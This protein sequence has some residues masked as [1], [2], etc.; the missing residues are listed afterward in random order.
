MVIKAVF[1]LRH[2]CA[3]KERTGK[4]DIGHFLINTV[5]LFCVQQAEVAYLT[6]LISKSFLGMVNNELHCWDLKYFHFQNSISK[7]S[8]LRVQWD[9]QQVD[10]FVQRNWLASW[11][12]HPLRLNH[13]STSKNLSYKRRASFSAQLTHSGHSDLIWGWKEDWVYLWDVWSEQW[14]VFGGKNKQ[15]SVLWRCYRCIWY[16]SQ[17]PVFWTL[18]PQL[19]LLLWDVL[20]N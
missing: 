20:G 12:P 8:L 17:R 13:Q 18:V 16:V 7:V 6:A 10:E 3:C 11:A 4:E 5:W 2:I 19:M 15:I 14:K 1:Y 9:W